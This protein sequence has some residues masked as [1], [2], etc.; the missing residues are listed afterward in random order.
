MYQCDRKETYAHAIA[1][2]AVEMIGTMSS[3]HSNAK[4]DVD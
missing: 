4:K 3:K 2:N 1:V